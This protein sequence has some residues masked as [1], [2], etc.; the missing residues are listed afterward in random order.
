MKDYKS[1]REQ[2]LE[3]K[4]NGNLISVDISKYG[5]GVFPKKIL[6]CIKYKCICH[7]GVCREERIKN[8]DRR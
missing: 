8:S 7:S 5:P 4:E 6:V 1:F 3:C 2:F